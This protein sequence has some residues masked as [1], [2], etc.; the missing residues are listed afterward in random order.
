MENANKGQEGAGE[1]AEPDAILEAISEIR[2]RWILFHLRQS[3]SAT[4]DDLEDIVVTEIFEEPDEADRE[5]VRTALHHVDLPKLER[6]GLI[7]YDP[8]EDIVKTSVDPTEIG[9][10]LDLAIRRDIRMGVPKTRDDAAESEPIHVLLVDDSKSLTDAAE[11]YFEANHDD[12]SVTT[13]T[14]V[15]QAISLLQDEPVDCIVSDVKMPAISGLDFLKAIRE[16]DRDIPFILFTARGSE[17]VASEA[18]AND[19]TRYVTKKDAPD[20]FDDLAEQ[21]RTVVDRS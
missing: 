9:E 17:E 15:E 21:I 20:Q 12:L 3:G 7:T 6:L 2:R 8:E 14:R 13:A 10:W 11:N 18:I 16:E 19:V 4:F 5:H 1:P